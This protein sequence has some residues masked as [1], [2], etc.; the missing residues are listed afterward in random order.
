MIVQ[1]GIDEANAVQNLVALG[2]TNDDWSGEIVVA[3]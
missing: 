3:Q 2:G 1:V